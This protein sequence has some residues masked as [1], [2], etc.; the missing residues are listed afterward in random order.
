MT[1]RRSAQMAVNRQRRAHGLEH[2]TRQPG[3]ASALLTIFDGTT[4]PKAHLFKLSPLQAVLL[5]AP[6]IAEFT[7]STYLEFPDQEGAG[8]NGWSGTL[9]EF[10]SLQGE[11]LN[12]IICDRVGASE[13]LTLQQVLQLVTYEDLTA[14]LGEGVLVG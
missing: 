8:V 1:N 6:Q 4:Q 10:V 5:V 12:E 11:A 2:T 7:A 3:L 13:P 9:G 14:V